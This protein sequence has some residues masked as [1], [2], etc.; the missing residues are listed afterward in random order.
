MGNGRAQVAK[1]AEIHQVKNQY[2]RELG[3]AYPDYALQIVPDVDV[4]D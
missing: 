1:L 3:Q 2:R 4:S